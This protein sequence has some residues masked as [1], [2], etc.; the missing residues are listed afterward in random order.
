MSR[1][2]IGGR[3]FLPYQDEAGNDTPI[4]SGEVI[5]KMSALT[6]DG[7]IVR[8]PTTTI[9]TIKNGVLEPKSLVF[10]VWTAEIRPHS[11]SGY[12]KRI[13]FLADK[14]EMDLSEVIPI[15]IDGLEYVKGEDGF[16]TE[17]QWNALV[18]RV[19]ALENPGAPESV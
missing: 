12:A 17:A 13:K 3:L 9:A 4:A 10:G 6:V 19:A 7:Q 5:Y 14:P 11:P 15:P 16:P 1:A 8:V 2:V 18:A